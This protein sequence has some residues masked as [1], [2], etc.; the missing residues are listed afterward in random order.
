MAKLIDK[1]GPLHRAPVDVCE[2]SERSGLLPFSLPE[3]APFLENAQLRTASG[4]EM[5]RKGKGYTLTY[6]E[7]P[8]KPGVGG[9][10]A[11]ALFDFDYVLEDD[12]PSSGSTEVMISANDSVR[13]AAEV[14]A[15]KDKV[16][17]EL[18]KILARNKRLKRNYFFSNGQLV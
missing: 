13:T 12:K 5:Q 18:E 10:I 2:C 4:V 11:A 16:A 8:I 9:M 14:L 15:V 6:R 17:D 3:L 7:G 1:S